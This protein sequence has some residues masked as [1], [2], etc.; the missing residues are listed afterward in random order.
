MRIGAIGCGGHGTTNIWPHLRGAGMELVATCARHLDRAEAAAAAWGAT[1]AFDD[2]AKML[3]SVEGLD[4]VVVVVPPDQYASILEVAIER[5]VPVFCDKPGAD[6]A[7]E[8]ADL[9]ARA[10]AAGVPVVVGYQKR[11][12][13]GYRQAKDLIDGGVIGSLTQGSFSWSM[14]PMG[15]N[16]RGWLFENPVHHFDLARYFFGELEDVSVSTARTGG[17]AL[18]INASSAAG[19]VVSLSINTNGSW[20]QHNEAMVVFGEGHAVVVDNI[21][22]CI[23]RPPERPE[24]VWRPN[25]T[26][27][28]PLNSSAA[29]MGFAPELEHFR[30]VVT[31]GAEN[32]SSIASAAA[33]L[34][35]TAEIA[36]RAGV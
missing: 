27:P 9:A 8:A 6:S 36:R 11:F 13:S 4:G 12:G 35:L 23:H 24:Q 2:P 16:L 7:E 33:T 29:T 15:D 5:G 22:T 3:D 34:A 31:E 17:H 14:G 20:F 30:A 19:A 10:E 28:M 26:V 21:D 18:A 25:Y 32:L 1:Q